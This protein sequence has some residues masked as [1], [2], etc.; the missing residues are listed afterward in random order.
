MFATIILLISAIIVATI[1]FIGETNPKLK[2]RIT[3]AIIPFSISIVIGAGIFVI[4]LLT[5]YNSY[6]DLYKY[7]QNILVSQQALKIY[8]EKGIAPVANQKSSEYTDFKYQNYQEGL[9]KLISELQNTINKYNNILIGKRIFKKGHV[10]NWYI[11]NADYDMKT[12][13]FNVHNLIK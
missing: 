10:W 8:M 5:S 1:F 9:Y 4:I 3:V 12:I 13:G 7:Q 2:N 6:L 11:I